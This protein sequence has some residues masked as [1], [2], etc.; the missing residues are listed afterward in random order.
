LQSQLGVG[1]SRVQQLFHD[2]LK[3]NAGLILGAFGSMFFLPSQSTTAIFTYLL[4]VLMLWQVPR[5]RGYLSDPIMILS[6]LLLGYLTLSS[7]WSA[8][9]E[10]GKAVSM[11][12]RTLSV[13]LFL[14]AFSECWHKGY[15]QRWFAKTLVLCG[16]G[17]AVVAIGYFLLSNP[18]D[19][20]LNGL[21]QLGAH[22]IAGL[23]FGVVLLF[24]LQSIR[25][26]A[27]SRW[28]M[29]AAGCGIVLLVA[30]ILTFSRNA[31][32]SVFAGIVVYCCAI[33]CRTPKQ[34][35]LLLIGLSLLGAI[36]LATLFFTDDGRNFLLPR[37]DSFR[38]LIWSTIFERVWTQAPIFGLG[39]LTP[40][41]VPNGT[42][43]HSHP[44]SMYLAV[45]Y[46]GGLLGL[47]LFLTLISL[48]IRTLITHLMDP[49][50]QVALGA[51]AIGLLSYFLDGHELVDRI[52]ETWMLFWLPVAISLSLRYRPQIR[53]P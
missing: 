37:G 17:A 7:A 47:G 5:W 13:L 10:P 53:K 45:L 4:G 28:R 27:S 32:V 1:L 30:L 35:L 15:L 21:G 26:D 11:G 34:L 33:R 41:D 36:T 18:E 46:Q 42:I 52:G 6:G 12:V 44:H 2:P 19:G 16:A 51:L 23:M 29:I 39:I 24:V 8:T 49:Q 48:V 40:D 38:P 43:L 9:D 22:V 14:V 31:W 50:A 25:D 3:V 20:R